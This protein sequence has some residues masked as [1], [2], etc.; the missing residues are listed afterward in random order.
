M[1]KNR[2]FVIN[3]F[4]TVLIHRIEW[5]LPWLYIM[6]HK[7]ESLGSMYNLKLVGY[8]LS[9]G[10]FLSLPFNVFPL[11]IFTIK[12]S[13]ATSWEDYLRGVF[14]RKMRYEVQFSC[15][16]LHPATLHNLKFVVGFTLG[17]PPK[18]IEQL[19]A[20]HLL[21]AVSGIIVL[22]SSQIFFIHS[23]PLLK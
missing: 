2:R 14:P 1:V 21:K 7:K 13:N 4:G 9:Q 3:N 20:E 5:G 19:S 23:R 18:F 16:Y 17:M 11:R 22:I 12:I 15:I 6:L 8:I 10:Q